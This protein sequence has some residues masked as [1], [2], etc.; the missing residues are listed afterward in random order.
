GLVGN[1]VRHALVVVNGIVVSDG[2]GVLRPISSRDVESVTTMVPLDAVTRYGSNGGN[3]A[4]L[5]TTRGS[6][7]PKN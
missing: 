2:R 4:I 6:R 7:L 3:G 1:P 5:I